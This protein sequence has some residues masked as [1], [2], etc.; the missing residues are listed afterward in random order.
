MATTFSLGG[1]QDVMETVDEALRQ[2]LTDMAVGPIWD[3]ESV[4]QMVKRVSA[5][6]SHCSSVARPTCPRLV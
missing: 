4:M 2:G 6:E 3:P 1:T 5:T